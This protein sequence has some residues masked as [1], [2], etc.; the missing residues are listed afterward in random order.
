MQVT[1]VVIFYSQLNQAAEEYAEWA[2]AM[3][4]LVESQPGFVRA[5]SFRNAEGFGVTLSYWDDLSS[6]RQWGRHSEHAKAQA[7]G[8]ETAY[9]NFRIEWAQILG[10]SDSERA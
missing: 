3:E 9:L 4:A 8:R 2:Q 6:I 1:H 10:S 5:H 7:Y